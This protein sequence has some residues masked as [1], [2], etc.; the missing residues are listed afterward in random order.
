MNKKEFYGTVSFTGK[1][2]FS[3]LGK[4]IE[5]A[6][7]NIFEDIE[8]IELHLKNGSSVEIS[9][10]EWDLIKEEASGNC[11]EAYINDFEISEEN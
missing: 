7:R 6:E 4:D 10:I 3:V 11:K 5:E 9:E 1:A 2:Y 8:G